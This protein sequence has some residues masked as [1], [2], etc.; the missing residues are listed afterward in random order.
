[1]SELPTETTFG[2]GNPAFTLQPEPDVGSETQTPEDAADGT[3]TGVQG[4]SE[5][6]TKRENLLGQLV[7]AG[8]VKGDLDPLTDAELVSLVE[9]V[10]AEN[11]SDGPGEG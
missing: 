4:G 10:E 5:L 8:Y 3:A 7:E 11:A 9:Q 6:P 1:M 2:A